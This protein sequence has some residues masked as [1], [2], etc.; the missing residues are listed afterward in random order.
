MV[1][2]HLFVKIPSPGNSKVIH[3][4]FKSSCH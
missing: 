4:V 2:A 3:L 1:L